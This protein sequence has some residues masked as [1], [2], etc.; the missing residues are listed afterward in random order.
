MYGDMTLTSVSYGSNGH[1]QLDG[2]VSDAI[3]AYLWTS[4][5]FLDYM[6]W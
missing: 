1:Q 3:G 4:V 2:K 6:F 5:T